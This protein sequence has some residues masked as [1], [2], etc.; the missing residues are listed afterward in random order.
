MNYL[1]QWWKDWMHRRENLIL[2]NP[3]T[4]YDPKIEGVSGTQYM[5]IK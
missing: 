3:E 2:W 5:R 4:F 1:A